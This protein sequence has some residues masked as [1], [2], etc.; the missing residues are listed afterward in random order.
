MTLPGSGSPAEDDAEARALEVA[1]REPPV[2]AG[3]GV[4]ADGRAEVVDEELGLGVWLGF[5]LWLGSGDDEVGVGDVDVDE[6]VGSPVGG[7]VG[8][9][10]AAAA[11]HASIAAAVA[12]TADT[13]ART[14][15][16]QF[17]ALP[18]PSRSAN[19]AGT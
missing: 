9:A 10:W 15:D 6:D 16:H 5:G 1:E 2:G 3:R 19:R 18:M 8:A 4:D 14:A 11:P 17:L 13:R 7:P 12:A